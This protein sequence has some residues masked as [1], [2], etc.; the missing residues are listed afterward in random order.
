MA[1]IW[2][3]KKQLFDSSLLSWLSWTKVLFVSQLIYSYANIKHL[4]YSVS[5]ET[6]L[7]RLQ[8]ISLAHDGAPW[9]RTVWN[10]LCQTTCCHDLGW[11]HFQLGQRR[12][13]SPRALAEGPLWLP[14]RG[15]NKHKTTV[16]M[17]QTN[18][19]GWFKHSSGCLER[20]LMPG[21]DGTRF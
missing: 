15:K 5:L 11:N 8:L 21:S 14:L 12:S 19:W 10:C 17:V 3:P 1:A 4:Q 7:Q 18:D 6:S 2:L 16:L 20:L 9:A 13:N